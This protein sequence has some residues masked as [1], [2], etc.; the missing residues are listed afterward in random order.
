[1]RLL[2]LASGSRWTVLSVCDARNH[3]LVLDFVETLDDRLRSNILSDLC[4]YVPTTDVSYWAKTDFS[5]RL[6]D[7]DRIFE[8]RWPAKKGGTARVLWFYGKPKEIVCTIGVLKKKGKLQRSEIDKAEE[9]RRAY[10]EAQDAG[11]L[12]IER[13]GG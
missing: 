4:E 10:F 13:Y 7:T 6:G 2:Q 8:F 1:M 11:K 3:C 12:A 9:C 5:K